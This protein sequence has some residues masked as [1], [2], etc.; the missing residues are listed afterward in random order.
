M[1]KQYERLVWLVGGDGM[2][3][4]GL[5]GRAQEENTAKYTAKMVPATQYETLAS[6]PKH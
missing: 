1:Q 4:R 5:P 2:T 6:I 3:Y